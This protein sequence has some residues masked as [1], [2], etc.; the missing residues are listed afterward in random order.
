MLSER[1]APPD[2]R[3]RNMR[4]SLLLFLLLAGLLPPAAEAR[5]EPTSGRPCEAV[6]SPSEFALAACAAVDPKARELLL[7]IDREQRAMQTLATAS[8][9]ERPV[10]WTKKGPLLKT[11]ARENAEWLKRVDPQQHLLDT[12]R[13]GPTVAKA[14]W[15]VVQHADHDPEWQA[16]TLKVLRHLVARRR[17]PPDLYAT[18]EDRVR[19]NAH[20][21]QLYG[22]QG[23]CAEHRWT[24]RPIE[25][26]AKVDRR[27]ARMGLRPLSEYSRRFS[28]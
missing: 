24:P 19:V 6:G 21:P 25:E 8:P 20:R 1:G 4:L 18:L 12:R 2:D 28:C 27:R 14:A 15:L 10:L 16:R 26:A 5:R 22:T 7:R 23:S 9:Q 13:S 11:M 3:A 17:F